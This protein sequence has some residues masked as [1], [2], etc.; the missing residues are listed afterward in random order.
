M[1]LKLCLTCR[2]AVSTCY[3]VVAPF[4]TICLNSASC[5]NILV[6]R[7]YVITYEYYFEF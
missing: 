1:L 2:L 3:L 6:V 5:V 7:V 4:K